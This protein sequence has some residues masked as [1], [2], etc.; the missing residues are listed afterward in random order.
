MV[1]VTLRIGGQRVYRTKVLPPGTTD[2]EAQRQAAD[3]RDALEKADQP[4]PAP[5]QLPQITFVAYAEQWLAGKS[6]RLR[7]AV[8]AEW[9]HR[10]AVH[11]LPVPVLGKMLGEWAIKDINRPLVECWVGWAENA[12]QANGK[13]YSSETVAGWWRTLGQVL[14]DAAADYELPDPTRRVQAPRLGHVPKVRTQETLTLEMVKAM[15]EHAKTVCPDRAAEVTFLAWTGCR[16]GEMFGLHWKD[17]QFG[18]QPIA[19]LR[20]S[21]TR[22]E[23]EHTKTSSPRRVPLLPKVVAALQAHKA[24]QDAGKRPNPLGLVFPAETGGYRLEQSLAKPFQA[25]SDRLDQKVTP[26]VLRRSLNTNLLALGIA[27]QEIQAILGHTTDAMTARYAGVGDARKAAALAA[28]Q[29]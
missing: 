22:G 14:R 28:L 8:A 9:S 16:S 5:P 19:V 24:V 3:L 27:T 23:L 29:D 10:L 21:A 11:I 13:P 4:P 7:G 20:H 12:K 18:D 26:Q 25:L 1:R 17:L 2:S 15:C 6:G